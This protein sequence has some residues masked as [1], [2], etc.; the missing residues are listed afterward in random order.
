MKRN[1]FTARPELAVAASFREPPAVWAPLKA[2]GNLLKTQDAK[3]PRFHGC[4]WAAGPSRTGMAPK[5]MDW[6]FS[7]TAKLC[8]GFGR[9]IGGIACLRCRDRAGAAG[10]P[11]TG[12][13]GQSQR[14]ARRLRRY[15]AEAYGLRCQG[16]SE[17]ERADRG[18]SDRD[19]NR[20]RGGARR[21]GRLHYSDQHR[22][23]AADVEEF[24]AHPLPGTV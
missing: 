24:E 21:Q 13:G 16:H 5:L 3:T 8:H 11:G 17:E 2:R 4:S 23:G 7:P 22:A 15:R 6:A 9:G 19:R 14:A 12:R 1:K 20:T 10:Q 18:T